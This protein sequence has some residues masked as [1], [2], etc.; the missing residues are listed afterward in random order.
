MEILYITQIA[1]IKLT[2]LFFFLRIFSK[3]V[4][5]NLFKYTIVFTTIYGL[6]FCF[7]AIFQCQP[8]KHFWNSWDGEHRGQCISVNG[9]VWVHAAINILLDVWMLAVPLHQVFQLQLS[10][11]KKISISLMFFIG[12][13]VTVVSI[14]RLQSLVHFASTRNPT[15]DQTKIITWSCTETNVAIICICMPTMRVMFTR[16]FPHVKGT[17]HRTESHSAKTFTHSSGRSGAEE[18]KSVITADTATCSGKSA[19]EIKFTQK[20]EVQH[21]DEEEMEL[22]DTYGSRSKSLTCKST[23]ASEA[24]V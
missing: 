2:L 12:T 7:A 6:A 23:R 21:A 3:K 16:L 20:F 9:I 19:N 14:I 18:R 8:I 11:E 13:F 5:Q 1:F 17:F 4:A 24:S 15:W 22:M 10:W